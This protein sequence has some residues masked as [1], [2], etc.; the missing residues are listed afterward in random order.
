MSRGNDNEV[1]LVLYIDCCSNTTDT[2]NSN[3]VT[4]ANYD[5]NTTNVIKSY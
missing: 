3:S 1:R 4:N 2:S 5:S